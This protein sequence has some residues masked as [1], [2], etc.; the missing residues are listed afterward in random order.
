MEKTFPKME[1]SEWRRRVGDMTQIAGAICFEY[2]SGKAKGTQA[3]EVRNGSGLRFVILPDRGMDIAYAEY[4][5]VP[6]SYISKNGVV[7]P[8]HYDEPDFLRSFTAGLLTTCG[9]TYMGAPCKDDGMVLGAHGRAANIPATDV[10]V[11]QEWVNGEF[12]IEVSGKVRESTVFGENIVLHRRIQVKMGDNRIHI[13]DTVENEGFQDTPLMMLYHMNYGFPLVCADTVLE[14]NCQNL[15]PRNDVSANGLSD[16]CRFQ[17]PTA[18]YEEQVFYRDAVAQSY[19][20]LYNPVMCFGIRLEFNGAELPYLVEWKQM[21]EQE[22]VVGVEPA[23]YP[24]DGRAAAR[25]RGEL[26]MLGAQQKRE[27]TITL[28]IVDQ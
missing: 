1:C 4:D 28:S 10:N 17:E 20:V 7:S 14:T 16:A 13:H 21:G 27:H 23:T 12:V 19:A 5:G 6:F 9:L 8:A 26:L 11:V 25:E 2:T 22:Y 18:G 15:R 3:I 24:P